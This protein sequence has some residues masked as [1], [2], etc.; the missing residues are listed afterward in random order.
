MTRSGEFR[1]G[2]RVGMDGM[3]SGGNGWRWKSDGVGTDGDGKHI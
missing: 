3:K 2:G 1:I